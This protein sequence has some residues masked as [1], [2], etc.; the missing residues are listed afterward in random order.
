MSFK[1]RVLKKTNLWRWG[2]VTVKLTLSSKALI[3][4][5]ELK[6]W[7]GQSLWHLGIGRK[8]LNILKKQTLEELECLARKI[9]FNH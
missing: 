9:V 3:L 7:V 2:N 8:Y 4:T 5:W 1:H 6:L